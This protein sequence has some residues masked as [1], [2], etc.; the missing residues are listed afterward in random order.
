MSQLAEN[1]ARIRENIRIAA[2]ESGRDASDITLV[3]ATK[4]RTAEEI[5]EA[6]SLGVTVCGENRVQEL[7]EKLPQGAYEGAKLHFIGRLQSNKVKYLVGRVDCIESVDSLKLIDAIAAYAARRNLRQDILIQI[8]PAGEE[9]KGGVARA[10]LAPMLH[11]V[12]KLPQIRL[13]GIMCIPPLV[14]NTGS[15]L[16]IFREM[17]QLYVDIIPK[18]LNNKDSMSCLS[19]GMSGDY[20]DAIR[21]G[22]THVRIGSALFGQRTYE[23]ADF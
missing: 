4:T 11:Y 8:N 9:Q 6:I 13:R 5:Q 23:I 17:H 7:T 16:E 10:Q 19:M 12:T 15:N 22:A 1:L 3:A 21:C 2:A 20:M 18:M 14:E